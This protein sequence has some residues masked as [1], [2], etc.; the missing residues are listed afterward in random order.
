M[1]GHGNS[2]EFRRLSGRCVFDTK[3]ATNTCVRDLTT[4]TH[5]LAVG[6]PG[7]IIVEERCLDDGLESEEECA[8]QAEIA[9]QN[10]TWTRSET[11]VSGDVV[12][13]N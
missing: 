8:E 12:R 11:A 3:T 5:C 4:D 7:E 1:S 6:E 2:E 13:R 10:F 9:R